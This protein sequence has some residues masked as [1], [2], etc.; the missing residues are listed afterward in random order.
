MADIQFPAKFEPLFKP[1]RYKVFWGGRGGA[2]SWNV[3]RWL[4]LDGATRKLRT[5][6]AREI[7]NSIKESVHK[8]LS[9]QIALMGLE[10]YYQILENEIRG[11][12]GSEF[13]FYGVRT[14]PTKI[15]STE[16]L[17]RCWIEEAETISERS[18]ELIIPTVRKPGSEIIVTFNPNEDTDPTYRRF[19]LQPPDADD[20]VVVKVGWED[21]PWFPEELRK[22]KDYLYRV[23]PEAAAHVW[24]G[25]CRKVSNAQILRGKYKVEAFTPDRS[26]ESGWHGPYFGAD[27]GF[28]EDPTVLI[29][30]WING[31]TLYIEHEAYGVAV[32]NDKIAEL[33]R[34]VPESDSHIIRADNSRPETIHHVHKKGGLNIHPAYKWPGSVEDGI[35]YL[36]SF[37]Q[38]VIHP[39]CKQT[40][41]EARLWRYKTDQ[42]TGDVLPIVVDAHNHCWDAVRYALE[43][44]I[45]RAGEARENP[46][47]TIK[48]EQL[49]QEWQDAALRAERA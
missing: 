18:W 37:E 38:I 4:L 16:G 29:K 11:R 1:K 35:Q 15:K 36:R 46:L 21:N 43:P 41:Q 22:E 34:T 23:D 44:I 10:S 13:I 39:D 49:P 27:W 2:K 40:I 8:L 17:D 48:K 45:Q 31:Q 30:C 5:L 28:A 25:E 14:N 47:S 24:G 42:L 12:N 26:I 7:Q 33:F 32:E 9:E 19:I 20:A 3:A 6:C